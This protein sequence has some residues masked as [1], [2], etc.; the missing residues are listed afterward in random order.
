MPASV[1]SIR[2]RVRV[3]P[4][5]HQLDVTVS[6]GDVAG[7]TLQLAVPTWVPGAYG[8]MKY[9]R[10]LFDVRARDAAG[11]ELAI[12]REGWS[13]FVI[14]NPPR[15][16]EISYRAGAFD[17]ALGSL[18]GLVSHDQAVLLLMRRTP[19]PRQVAQALLQLLQIGS[20]P[21]VTQPP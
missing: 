20:E 2:Y 3:L 17:P 9:G 10:D 5:R 1:G 7:E 12:T 21:R 4:E 14:R 6:I 13:G 11:N 16:V 19:A 8:F 18:S 15:V